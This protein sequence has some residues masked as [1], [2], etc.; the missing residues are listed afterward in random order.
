[1]EL[2]EGTRRVPSRLDSLSLRRFA[3]QKGVQKLKNILEGLPEAQF[4]A[5]EYMARAA[6]QRGSRRGARGQASTERRAAPASL[7]LQ[8]RQP[9]RL[10][11]LRPT[12]NM[13]TCV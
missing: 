3:P 13:Y 2:H 8:R 11:P 1:M 6:A 9:H 4:N 5:E 12:Q 7:R 10:T